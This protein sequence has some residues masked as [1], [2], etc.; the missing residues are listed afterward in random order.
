MLWIASHFR[1]AFGLPASDV[2][3][4][5]A[6][7]VPT[8]QFVEKQGRSTGRYLLTGSEGPIGVFVKKYYRLPWWQ[9]WFAPPHN[10]PGPRELAALRR[11]AALGISAPEEMVRIEEPPA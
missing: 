5:L 7:L 9:R 10:L 2:Y 6:D 1:D 3:G 11:V 4:A 8:D